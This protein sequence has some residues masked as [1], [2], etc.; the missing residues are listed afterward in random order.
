MLPTFVKNSGEFLVRQSG[1]L[2][3]AALLFAFTQAA[4]VVSAFR[5]GVSLHGAYLE[6]HAGKPYTVLLPVWATFLQAVTAAVLGTVFLWIAVRA[7]IR[8][9]RNTRGS[10]RR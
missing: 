7:R 6:T 1:I 10:R 5:H 3:F 9:R 4:R 8:V 2:A